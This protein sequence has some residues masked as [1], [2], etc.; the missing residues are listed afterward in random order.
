MSRP[1]LMTP[2][3]RPPEPPPFPEDEP[4][5]PRRK[6][7]KPDLEIETDPRFPSG[8]WVGFYLMKPSPERHQMELGL[9]FRKGVM[10]GEG[11]DKIG[12][13]LIRGKYTVEDGKCWWTKSYIG[14]HDVFYHG[15]N[16]GKGIWG[17]WEI[18]PSYDGGF[19]I[20]PV[21]IGDPTHPR[22]A[23]AVDRPAET[24]AE[25]TVEEPGEVTV[26]E[27]LEVGAPV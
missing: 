11:R 26:E 12:N 23:E 22:L 24:E 2:P 7:S 6:R 21:G 1:D 20:W 8:P 10:T 4:V 14:R 19:H 27:P 15:Y 9:S 18:P 16:E 13:F 5:D 3:P 17:I 25:V